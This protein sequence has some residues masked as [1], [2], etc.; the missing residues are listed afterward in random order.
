MHDFISA[1]LSTHMLIWPVVRFHL[2]ASVS[3][4]DSF[5]DNLC[6]HVLSKRYCSSSRRPMCTDKPEAG[7]SSWRSLLIV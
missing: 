5:G 2:R 4:S 6:S 7:N 1:C 3:V